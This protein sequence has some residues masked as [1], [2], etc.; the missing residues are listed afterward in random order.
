MLEA[1]RD[2]NYILNIVLSVGDIIGQGQ[3]GTVS[4]RP[5]IHLAPPSLPPTPTQPKR[6]HP[7][8]LPV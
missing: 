7:P 8:F 1:A 3:Y 5:P 2:P 6:I 4:V